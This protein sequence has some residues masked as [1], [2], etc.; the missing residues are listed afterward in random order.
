MSI[1]KIAIIM[2]FFVSFIGVFNFSMNTISN[3]KSQTISTNIVHFNEYKISGLEHI[4]VNV[5]NYE[6]VIGWV[7]EPA[8]AGVFNAVSVEI[9]MWTNGNTSSVP[10]VG[11]EANL[12]ITISKGGVS[13]P[14]Q[15]LIPSDEVPGFYTVPFMPSQVGGTYVTHTN[16]ILGNYKITDLQI[17]LDDPSSPLVFPSIQSSSSSQSTTSNAPGFEFIPLLF[18]MSAIALVIINR[19]LK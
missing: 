14:P 4:H 16:G 18:G 7:N 3:S 9:S 6:I 12:T 2:L 17:G 8:Y 19:R 13:T 1:V 5:S 10:I 15:S 11:A